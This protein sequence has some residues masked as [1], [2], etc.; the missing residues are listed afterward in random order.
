VRTVPSLRDSHN[1]PILTRHFRAGLSNAAAAR[2]DTEGFGPR[3][4]PEFGFALTLGPRL[5]AIAHLHD[6]QGA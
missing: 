3:R 1:F 5:G 2:L 4:S 6:T